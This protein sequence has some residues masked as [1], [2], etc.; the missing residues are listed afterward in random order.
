MTGTDVATVLTFALKARKA[1][2]GAHPRLT[3]WKGRAASREKDVLQLHV[4]VNGSFR[5][6]LLIL[7]GHCAIMADN[8]IP[9]DVSQRARV[10]GGAVVTLARLQATVDGTNCFVPSLCR[11]LHADVARL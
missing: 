3:N 6:Q 11:A 8:L 9:C 1:S 4:R 5:L 2:F 10:T 7:N